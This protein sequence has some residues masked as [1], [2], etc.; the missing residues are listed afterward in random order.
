[1][2]TRGNQRVLAMGFNC[3]FV[4]ISAGVAL[5]VTFVRRK[6]IKKYLQIYLSHLVQGVR[7]H[8]LVVELSTKRNLLGLVM[9]CNAF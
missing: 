8:L 9:A 4:D 2:L 5:N 6:L 1:M 7:L 3:L